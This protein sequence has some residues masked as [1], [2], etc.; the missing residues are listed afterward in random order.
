M[1]ASRTTKPFTAHPA[2]PVIVALW[3]AALLGLGTFVVPPAN[4]EGLVVGTGLAN[5]VPAAAPPLGDT[6]RLAISAV[7]AL[8]GAL[9]GLAIAARVRRVQAAGQTT[10]QTQSEAAEPAQDS[11]WLADDD[12]TTM[13][14]VAEEASTDMAGR[15]D[16]ATGEGT[17][18]TVG[19]VPARLARRHSLSEREEPLPEEQITEEQAAEEGLAEDPVER[20]LQASEIR[21][22]DAA[23][24]ETVAAEETE[25]PSAD[26][27]DDLDRFAADRLVAGLPRVQRRNFDEDP[28]EDWSRA[29]PVAEEHELEPN[30]E[31]WPEPEHEHIGTEPRDTD[32]EGPD[33]D[34]P[35]FGGPDREGPERDGPELIEEAEY[36]D[37][38]A[39][40]E[41]RFDEDPRSADPAEAPETLQSPPRDLAAASLSELVARFD[42]ALA[43]QRS[44]SASDLA[45]PADPQP[46]SGPTEQSGDPVIAFLRREADR[47]R[48]APGEPR[49]EQADDPRAGLRN[50]LD[51]LDRVSRKS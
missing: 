45:A 46:A 50:A 15:D 36:E 51:K 38:P 9:L 3:F 30:L 11:P 7:A 24:A 40:P 41:P 13:Q 39:E 2:F 8:L 31:A 17:G 12:E 33:F 6:A 49:N 34:E 20:I 1:G 21:L 22:E 48:G 32:R 26:G 25:A 37:I 16:S 10:A 18:E 27:D 29:E 43:A 5:L 14:E 28:L 44:R 47:D 35:D 19:A 42:A 4:F 23:E